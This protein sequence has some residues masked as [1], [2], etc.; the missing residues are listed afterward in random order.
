M[1]GV[2][3]SLSGPTAAGIVPDPDCRLTQPD[4]SDTVLCGSALRQGCYSAIDKQI[5]VKCDSP[6]WVP[7]FMIGLLQRVTKAS[8]TVEGDVIASIGSGLMV[9]VAVQPADTAAS[10]KR[11]AE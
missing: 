8:V 9:L 1:A 7:E 6:A 11:L 4:P 3:P 2:I 10:A 5:L